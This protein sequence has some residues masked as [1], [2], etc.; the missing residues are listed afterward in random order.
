ME[1]RTAGRALEMGKTRTG[2]E[3]WQRR[4][5]KD[6]GVGCPGVEVGRGEQR[7]VVERGRD[8]G[9]SWVVKDEQC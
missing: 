9:A 8:L 7:P 2:Q 3:Q 1:S 4:G 6:R 5:R